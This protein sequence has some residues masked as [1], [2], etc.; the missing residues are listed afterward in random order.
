MAFY[1]VDGTSMISWSLLIEANSEGEASESAVQVAGCLRD[2]R[3]AH[4]LRDVRHEV[5]GS[6]RL[7]ESPALDRIHQRSAAHTGDE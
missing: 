1:Q 4:A 2:L 5:V 6:R 3:Q 7:I